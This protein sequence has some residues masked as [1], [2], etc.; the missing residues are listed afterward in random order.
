MHNATETTIT[1][2]CQIAF[3]FI[4]EKLEITTVI[5]DMDVIWNFYQSNY[6]ERNN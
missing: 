5:K 4:N 6:K 2:V 3:Q 1:I